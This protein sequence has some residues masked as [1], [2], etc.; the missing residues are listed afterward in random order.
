MSIAF[1]CADDGD[2][3][4]RSGLTFGIGIGGGTIGCGNEGCDDLEGAGSLDLHIGG[5]LG[6]NV[7]LRFD[8]WSMLH[9]ENRVTVDQGILTAAARSWPV[10][11]FWLQFGLGAARAQ[12]T[13]A[14]L[15]LCTGPTHTVW[16]QR[17]RRHRPKRSHLQ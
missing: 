8:A 2:S 13:Y 9:N 16:L 17:P 7:A 12:I 6:P 15:K 1:V 14:P 5:M 4:G 10:R 11:H 3:A